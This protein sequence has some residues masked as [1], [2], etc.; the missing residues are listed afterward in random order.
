MGNNN[1]IRVVL[2]SLRYKSAPNTD[3]SIKL[4]LVQ[5]SKEIVEYDRIS[6]VDL[7]QVY[8]DE[9]Q[10]STLFRPAC[11]FILIFKNSY[12]GS[13]NYPPFENNLYYLDTTGLAAAQCALGPTAVSWSGIP[14]YNEFDFIRTD[15]NNVGYTQP[16][17]EHL[18]F[19]PKSASTY[20]WN[21]F[22]SYPYENDY[23]KSLQA[24]DKNTLQTLSWVSG[25]GIPFVIQS[26]ISNGQN[27]ISFRCPVKHGVKSGEF[28]K[29]KFDSSPFSYNGQEIFQVE[30]TGLETYGS[31][32]YILN[33]TDVGYTGTTFGNGRT[34]TF[35]RVILDSSTADTVSK[36]YVRKHKIL[37]D[38]DD[39][40]LAKAGFE[41]NIF[42]LKKKYESSGF[43][44]NYT[45]RVSIK[46]GSQSYTTSF[47]KD[48]D[49]DGLL[50]NLGR[51]ITQLFFTVI[52]K[53]Y[54][55]W[56]TGA[57]KQGYEF[58]LPL[59]PNNLPSDWW[60][61]TNT[62]SNTQFTTNNYVNSGYTFFYVES[63][64]SDD[65]L[66]GDL[67][68]WNDFEQTERVISEIY[69]KFKFNPAFFNIASPFINPLGYY[70]K[71]LHPLTLRV[72]SSYIETADTNNIVDLP[73][74]A[75]YSSTLNQFIWRDIYTYG[76]FDTETKSGVNYPFLNGG[77]YPFRNIIF[78]I[79]PEGTNYTEQIVIAEPTTDECE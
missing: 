27:N 3:F 37:T 21:I 67:C 45:A 34:G 74:Y 69:H 19:V 29:I 63:L 60:R 62:L 24:V 32:E 52:W 43:T 54:F 13:T 65:V 36:Y 47:N 71:P 41:E 42:G 53:G 40:V 59:K 35:K 28:I 48:I 7:Q 51:P 4:P 17:N 16:P 10:A 15:Y 14:Q 58:N 6:N 44:P 61:L 55:G 68:E 9:R 70:Y 33:L 25:D 18:L 49:I 5:N 8:D 57:I 20:N 23:N 46:E 12:A 31:N 56:T 30:S 22:L 64:K 79:I 66:E 75:Y 38:V 2:G 73:N 77:H 50:D 76:F 1:E 26:T 39:C 78:R 11:K 72:Y